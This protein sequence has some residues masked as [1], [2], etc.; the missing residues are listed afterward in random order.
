MRRLNQREFD[1]RGNYCAV[2]TGTNRAEHRR[3]SRI[4]V[5]IKRNED[6]QEYTYRTQNDGTNV[7]SAPTT[8]TRDVNLCPAGTIIAEA[9]HSTCLSTVAPRSFGTSGRASTPFV[10]L[11]PEKH[12]N[13]PCAERSAGQMGNVR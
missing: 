1:E 6:S 4:V 11:A 3:F 10:R 9:G 8:W 13:G 2:P 12:E 5:K 7:L